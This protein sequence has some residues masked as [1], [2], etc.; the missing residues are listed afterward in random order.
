[1]SRS[2]YGSSW[3]AEPGPLADEDEHECTHGGIT[4]PSDPAPEHFVPCGQSAIYRAPVPD[5]MGT[6]A[7]CPW[8]LARVLEDHEA[9]VA[10]ELLLNRV[11]HE[12][13]DEDALVRLEDA[14]P[15]QERAGF[16][17]IRIGLDQRGEV[18][19]FAPEPRLLSVVD[20]RLEATEPI[21]ELRGRPL[22]TYLE[23]VAERR[24]WAAF[25]DRV[26]PD[27]GGEDGGA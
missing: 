25:D 6:W 14:P 12:Y 7:F 26:T 1:M 17:W 21:R 2:K 24:G 13:I 20:E 9:D 22:A 16:R 4:F 15:E 10:A 19:Y 18:H 23:F 3:H 27:E 5:S 11:A 8:H